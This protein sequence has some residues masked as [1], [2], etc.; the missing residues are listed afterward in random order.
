MVSPKSL[1]LFGQSKVGKTTKLSELE[2]CLIIDTENGTDFV[3][4]MSVKVN[5]LK[6][7]NDLVKALAEP[8]ARRYKYIALDTVDNVALWYEQ[9]VVKRA[10]QDNP[11]IKA[12]IDIPYGG[13]YGMVRDYVG[14]FLRRLKQFSDRVIE[15]GHRKK[16][17]IGEDS[18]DLAELTLDLPGK[19]KNLIMADAD[20]IGYVYRDEE[21]SQ[22][23]VSFKATGVVDAGSRCDHLRNQVIPFEWDKIYVD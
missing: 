8:G 23:M 10:T 15:I 2:D 20:A 7:L 21:T 13:G 9:F 5:N 12:L 3:E 14:E 19:L 6:D 1:L 4:S 16:T 18:N 11:K 17:I 22:L